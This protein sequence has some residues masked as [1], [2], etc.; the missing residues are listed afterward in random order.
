MAHEIK[1]DSL[2]LDLLDELWA[3]EDAGDDE[4][5]FELRK[6]FKF[7]ASSLMAVKE[8]RGADWIRKNQLDTS[9]ADEK[10]GE[11]WLDR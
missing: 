3:A 6:K 1:T 2:D 7:T 11:G 10:Y 4:R 5:A 9:K 8:T